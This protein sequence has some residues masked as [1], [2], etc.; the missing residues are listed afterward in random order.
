MPIF[1]KNN[2]QQFLLSV[3]KMND[4]ANFENNFL[5]NVSVYSTIISHSKYAI[6]IV[7]C[8][9]IKTFYFKQYLLGGLRVNYSVNIKTIFHIIL[10][11]IFSSCNIK[12]LKKFLYFLKLK[13]VAQLRIKD[14]IGKNQPRQEVEDGY[15]YVNIF[16][17]TI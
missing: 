8:L 16:V 9:D 4:N 14:T 15:I 11:V 1:D 3:F 17:K 13:Y 5:Y 2:F 6:L 12:S 7:L 10:V